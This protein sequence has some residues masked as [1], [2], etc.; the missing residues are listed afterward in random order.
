MSWT[1]ERV[2]YLKKLWTDGLSASQIAGE[3]GQGI[4]RNAVIGKVHRLGLAGREKAAAAPTHAAP[5]PRVRPAAPRA[6]VHRSSTVSVGNTALAVT[7]DLVPVIAPRPIEDIVIPMS[8]R[9]T[10]MELRESMC[11]WPLGDPTTSEFRFCGSKTPGV[12][13]YCAHHSRIA[14]QPPQDRRRER[15]RERRA[16]AAGR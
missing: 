2:E 16:A 13:A 7:A 1:D 6:P 3:L 11:R 4:T 5:R 12:G 9:V 8:E 14:Y 15:E 10:L